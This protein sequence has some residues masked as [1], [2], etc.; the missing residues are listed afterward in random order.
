MLQQFR[1]CLGEGSVTG[2]ARQRSLAA[3]RG[4]TRVGVTANQGRWPVRGRGP[5]R[6]EY[7]VDSSDA[8]F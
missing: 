6:E 7:A 3:G 2:T 1:V 5:F 8:S 4:P